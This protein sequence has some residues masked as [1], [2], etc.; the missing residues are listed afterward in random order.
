MQREMAQK[1]PVV[2]R[3]WGQLADGALAEFRVSN[4][5]GWC[6]IYLDRLG[7]DARQ[8]DLATAM[9]ITQPSTVHVINQLAQAGF[10]K[11]LR[12]PEDKRSNR[13]VLTPEGRDLVS[14][15]EARLA[16]LRGELFDGVSGEDIETA[17][18]VL[19]VLSVRIAE[20]RGA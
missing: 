4:S 19:D 11:R 13:I 5:M 7:Q 20:R 16:D 2:T 14:K 10:V 3:G 12:H 1:L 9:G 18:R 17:L 8:I 6:L 15:I